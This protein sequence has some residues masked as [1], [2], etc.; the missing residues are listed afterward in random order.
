MNQAFLQANPLETARL[1]KQAS[2]L[3]NPT[4][5]QLFLMA[6][7]S[8]SFENQNLIKNNLNLLNTM[9]KLA[10]KSNSMNNSLLDWYS[11]TNGT[12]SVV[13]HNLN[14]NK[15]PNMFAFDFNQLKVAPNAN[16]QKLAQQFMNGINKSLTLFETQNNVQRFALNSTNG[17]RDQIM[18]KHNSEQEKIKKNEKAD[19]VINEGEFDFN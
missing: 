1:S 13:N 18:N 3:N 14:I 15:I 10:N 4:A 19:A 2:F 5:D 7:F 9:M 17:S 11:L 16:T 6:Q 8:S 12:N